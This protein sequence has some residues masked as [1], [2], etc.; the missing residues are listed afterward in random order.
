M[1]LSIVNSIF[2]WCIVIFSIAGYF[3]TLRNTG[4]RWM[5]W[6][7]LAS[8]WALFAA[9]H[10]IIWS[11]GQSNSAFIWALWLSSYVLIVTSIVLIFLKLVDYKKRKDGK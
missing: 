6:I 1:V 11:G 2:A 3:L 10:T 8:G 9:A 7:V 4:E 5:F